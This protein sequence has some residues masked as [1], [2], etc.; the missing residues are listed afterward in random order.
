MVDGGVVGEWWRG[1]G[2]REHCCAQG[3]GRGPQG[4]LQAALPCKAGGNALGPGPCC[5][6]FA[7]AP[8]GDLAAAAGQLHAQLMEHLTPVQGGLALLWPVACCGQWHAVA[9]GMLLPV[10]CC[11]QWHAVASGMLWPVAC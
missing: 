8:A 4:A 9:S 1:Q 5:R 2:S 10:A 11:C 7:A 6:A 3:W